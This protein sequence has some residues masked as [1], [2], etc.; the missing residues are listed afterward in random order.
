MTLNVVGENM[1]LMTP[2]NLR[3]YC[4]PYVLEVMAQSMK[5]HIKYRIYHKIHI[6]YI[7]KS[8]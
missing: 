7:I 1:K 8:C 2:K 6:K 5:I 3:L 4:W